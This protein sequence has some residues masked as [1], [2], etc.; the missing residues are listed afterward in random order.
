MLELKVKIEMNSYSMILIESLE[1][2]QRRGVKLLK[3]LEHKSYEEQLRE[4]GLFNMEKRRLR[5]NLITLKQL[6]ERRLKQGGS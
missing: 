5:E 3:G 6:P 2:V 1:C 4:E